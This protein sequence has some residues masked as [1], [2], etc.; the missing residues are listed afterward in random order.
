MNGVLICCEIGSVKSLVDGSVSVTLLTPEISGGKVGELFDLRKKIA[1][2]YISARQVETN[3]KV[4][5]DGL[6]PEL[7]G[8]S[9]GQRLRNVLFIKWQQD[10]E[11][12]KDSE[13]YY[14]AK[15]ENLIT[16]FKNELV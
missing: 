11:G 13:S 3:E 12:Y 5:V 8:K 7:K 6:N 9:P 2:V 16:H 4:I 10:N 14:V 1:Y 15:M